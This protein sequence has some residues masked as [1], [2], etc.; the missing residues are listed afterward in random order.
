[1]LLYGRHAIAVKTAARFIYM[2]GFMDAGIDQTINDWMEALYEFP[3]PVRVIYKQ[4]QAPAF[5]EK[6]KHTQQNKQTNKQTNK[7][8]NKQA[9]K[10]KLSLAYCPINNVVKEG[11]INGGLGRWSLFTWSVSR[12]NAGECLVV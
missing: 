9:N 8:Q 11:Y 6:K 10:K 2:N 3:F 12:E 1:M 4:R 7:Q 5:L